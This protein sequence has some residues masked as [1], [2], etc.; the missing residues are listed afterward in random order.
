[1]KRGSDWSDIIGRKSLAEIKYV[2]QVCRKEDHIR[3]FLR[4]YEAED[5][6]ASVTVWA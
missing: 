2:M 6:K 3:V 4:P 1:M 5:E